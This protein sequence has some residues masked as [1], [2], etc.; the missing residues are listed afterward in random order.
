MYKI[1]INKNNTFETVFHIIIMI[2]IKIYFFI[3]GKYLKL[4]KMYLQNCVNKLLY[5]KPFKL[6]NY[7]NLSYCRY[8]IVLFCFRV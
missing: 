3:L 7:H 4:Y 6:N 8:I 5:S 1:I 2:N